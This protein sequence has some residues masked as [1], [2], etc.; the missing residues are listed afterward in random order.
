[1][2]IVTASLAPSRQRQPPHIVGVIMLGRLERS[3]SDAGMIEVVGKVAHPNLDR[4]RN[5]ETKKNERPANQPRHDAEEDTPEKEPTVI[6][7]VYDAM[8]R[9]DNPFPHSPL[10]EVDVVSSEEN[11]PA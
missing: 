3:F 1:M 5:D 11:P 2:E 9:I 7:L 8:E 4:H 6:V 10:V